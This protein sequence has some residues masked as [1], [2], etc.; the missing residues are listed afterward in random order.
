[1]C[2]VHLFG[3]NIV[4]SYMVNC[5]YKIIMTMR[6]PSTPLSSTPQVF[7]CCVTYLLI[8]RRGG[9]YRQP[10]YNVHMIRKKEVHRA[11]HFS[12]YTMQHVWYVWYADASILFSHCFVMFPNG[13][14]SYIT[15]P[16]CYAVVH[17]WSKFVPRQVCVSE[18]ILHFPEKRFL[19]WP[20]SS[21]PP[22]FLPTTSSTCPLFVL[23]QVYA[24]LSLNHRSLPMEYHIFFYKYIKHK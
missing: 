20:S 15:L 11:P 13:F 12:I 21:W 2:D 18:R 23:A 5:K 24:L 7:S 22:P 6:T 19:W 8:C 16:K 17:K 3:H 14:T 4:P 9:C 10:V 1:M